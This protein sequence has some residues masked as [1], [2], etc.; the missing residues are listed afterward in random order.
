MIYNLIT[1][2]TSLPVSLAEGK[3]H[4]RVTH[5]S[6]DDLITDLI[7]A[8]TKEFENRSNLCLTAQTWDLVLSQAEV[9]SRIGFFKFPVASITS[10]SYYDGDNASQ[11]TTDYTLFSNGRPSSIRFDLDS[12]E[13]P[14]VYDRDDSMTIRFVGGY[15]SLPYDIKQ[16]L[17]ARLFRIYENPNDPVSERM[18]YFDKVLQSYRSFDL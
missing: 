9:T 13:T 18:S 8:A 17:L 14:T 6:H 16:A 11:T 15:T 5:S 1:P 7:W 3:S 12:D 10:V 2:A 4:L